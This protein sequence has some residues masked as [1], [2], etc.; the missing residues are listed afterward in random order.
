MVYL[1]KVPQ[2]DVN[3]DKVT[4]IELCVESDQYVEK[5]ATLLVVE[6]LKTS[7]TIHS[8]RDGYVRR[9]MVSVA[10]EVSVGTLILV[11]TD[12]VDEEIDENEIL[13]KNLSH[14][15]STETQKYDDSAETKISFKAKALAKRLNIDL[16][17]ITPKNGRIKVEDIEQYYQTSGCGFE[18]YTRVPFRA[19]KMNNVERG[20][21]ASLE[22]S[23]KAASPAYLEMVVN[24]KPLI[25]FSEQLKN[26]RDWFFNPLFSLLAWQ[27]S[28]LAIKNRGLNST[29]YEQHIIEYE[30]INLGFTVD[31]QGQL[32]LAVL[33]DIEQYNQT[34]FVEAFFELQRKAMKRQLAQEQLSG[35]TLGITSLSSFGVTK[36]QPIL[37]PNT[38]VMLAHSANLPHN[39]EDAV[40]SILGVT[41]D[42]K[43]HSGV[44]I[45]KMLKA[46]SANI[47]KLVA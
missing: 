29:Q 8:D 9:L 26:Q 22:W 25:D 30:K 47:S 32:F 35:C 17:N 5:D 16:N 39:P 3:D 27:Y 4:I 33:D 11:L 41:Y 21:Q 40:Y 34:S 1:V 12:T 36:H 23:N 44:Q 19:R 14:K 43:V 38:S 18:R 42:H 37:P 15:E 45:A 31:V 24:I 6:T 28:Q 7:L 13:R 2:V 46:L 20:M 10:D